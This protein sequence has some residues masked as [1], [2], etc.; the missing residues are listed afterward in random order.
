[1]NHLTVTPF[2]LAFVLGIAGMALNVYDI[3]ARNVGAL[4]IEPWRS[5]ASSLASAVRSRLAWL[6]SLFTAHRLQLAA[7][8]LVLIAL[9]A[10]GDHAQGLLLAGVGGTL[11]MADVKKALDE[12]GQLYHGQFKSINEKIAELEKEGRAVD[13]LL[14]ET[15][16]KLNE[17]MEKGAAL[18]EAF[19]KQSAVV[20]RLE[21][22]GLPSGQ[23]ERNIEAE[24]KAFN[25]E[26]RSIAGAKGTTVAEATVDEYVA[27]TKAFD[28]YLRVGEKALTPDEARALSVG[29]DSSGGYLVTPDKSGQL[30]RKIFET[31]DVRRY[32]SV[33]AISTDALE[34]SADLDEASGG[35][36]S[37]L[38]SRSDSN[39]PA[40]PT[41]WRIPVHE[42]YS[43]PKASQKL[44]NDASI[45]VAAWLNGK[46]SDKL[47]RDQN[48][49]FVTGS[50]VGKPRGFASYTTS[51]TYAWGTPEHVGTGTSGGWGTDP[52]GIQKLNSLMG[53]LKDTY[54]QGSNFF[55]N[56]LTKFSIRNLTDASSAGKFVFIPSF[57][58]GVPD[59]LLGA[60]IAVFQ[61]MANYTTASALA[62]AYGNMARY[63]QIVDRQGVSVLVDPYT[64]KPYVVFYTTAR[65]GGDVIDFEAMKFLKFA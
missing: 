25:I 14:K 24:A 40:V 1:M 13:P 52:N 28:R 62:V 12:A 5:K 23:G 48:V 56:R 39:T 6:V 42:Q 53:L 57:Q 34:G 11:E 47:G 22:M 50:G 26:R 3:H 19:M 10:H 36:V 20:A 61:D 4:E 38:G 17:A 44:I 55:M 7:A 51:T 49:A 63:Y 31:S 33:Q 30:V 9:Y 15:R 16:E 43:Q 32:A 2:L 60:P 35:W 64:A 29:T 58:A 18:N 45:D 46:V 27:Y 8:A 41:P 37:E 59:M 65:V 21:K 54:V